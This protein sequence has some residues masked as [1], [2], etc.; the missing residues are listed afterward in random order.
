MTLLLL[1]GTGEA[2]TIAEA[3][4]DAKIPA[5]ASLAGATRQPAELAI[6]TRIGGYGDAA[7]FRNYLSEAGISA[8]LDATHPFAVRMSRRSLSVATELGLPYAQ[9]LRPA[10]HP[11]PGD[12]WRMLGAEH[13]AAVHIP[14][15]TTVFLATGRQTLDHF[16]NL[17]GRRLICR[18]I[19][20]PGRPFPFPGGEFR[21]GRPPF[22]IEEEVALFRELGVDWLVVKN[23]GGEASRSKLDAARQLGIPVAMIRR[24]EALD[25]HRLESV[26]SAMEWVRGLSW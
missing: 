7:G 9:Y 5:V 22:S 11:G 1:A 18:Q 8:L 21:I 12:D 13:E 14:K 26:E 15:G 6:S 20:P 2:R 24:P 25:C 10:W 4:A 19:D 16:A 23:A 3:L 17:M